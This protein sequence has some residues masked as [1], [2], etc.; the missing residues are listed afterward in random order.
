MPLF[1][2]KRMT[3]V[4]ARSSRETICQHGLRQS[5]VGNSS[6]DDRSQAVF[7]F[8]PSEC[9]ARSMTRSPADQLAYLYATHYEV[10]QRLVVRFAG[11]NPIALE[12]SSARAGDD[13]ASGSSATATV[14]FHYPGAGR[15]RIGILRAAVPLKDKCTS[16]GARPNQVSDPASLADSEE[17]DLVTRRRAAEA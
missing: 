11:Q 1:L 10:L 17:A 2:R 13:D 6:V 12:R 16:I 9:H 15:R 7:R 3:N 5:C 4:A 14:A 8:T